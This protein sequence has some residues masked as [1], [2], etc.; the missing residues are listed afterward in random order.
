MLQTMAS[1]PEELSAG[2]ERRFCPLS[3]PDRLAPKRQRIRQ[4]TYPSKF[5]L[6]MICEWSRRGPRA[7]LSL[8]CR[9]ATVGK[10]RVA[11]SR[12]GN[13]EGSESKLP[14]R[15][16]LGID[17]SPGGCPVLYLCICIPQ[18]HSSHPRERRCLR[19]G[20]GGT[21][22]VSGLGLYHPMVAPHTPCRPVSRHVQLPRSPPRSGSRLGLN[23]VWSSGPKG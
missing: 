20:E 2:C 10:P 3:G 16:W 5:P 7:P 23:P 15:E 8:S 12:G 11:T 1:S 14:G 19:L 6:G 22:L 4:I 18:A 17:R 13:L 9:H 21:E